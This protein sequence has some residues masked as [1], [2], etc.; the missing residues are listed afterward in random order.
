MSN[1]FCKNSA[2]CALFFLFFAIGTI[3]G[4]F[5]LRF[6]LTGDSTWLY[7]Y[8]SSL[9]AADPSSFFLLLWFCLLPFGLALVIYFLPCKDR[10]FPALFYL[11]GLVSA[12]TIGAFVALG[13]SLTGILIVD[14]FLLPAFYSFCR[15]LWGTPRN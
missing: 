12:Y 6:I 3:C 2:F 4:N 14:L 10:L 13:I 8:C 11:Q 9:Q 7:A 15:K 1:S 5:L